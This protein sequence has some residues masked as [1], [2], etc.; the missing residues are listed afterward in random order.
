MSNLDEIIQK[1][2]DVVEFENAHLKKGQFRPLKETTEVKQKCLTELNVL[3]SQNSSGE[4]GV[5]RSTHLEIIRELLKENEFLMKS[6]INTVKSAYQQINAIRN[7]EAK[8]GAYDRFGKT[9]NL[10]DSQGLR[11]KLV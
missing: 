10:P 3:V 11:K 7:R 1:L 4:E 5:K 6:A 9:I 2:R 8:V